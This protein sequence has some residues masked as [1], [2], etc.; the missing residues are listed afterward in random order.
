MQG[1]RERFAIGAAVLGAAL[2]IGACGGDDAETPTPPPGSL[3]PVLSTISG[4]SEGSPIGVGWMS[5]EAIAAPAPMARRL[6]EALGPNGSDVYDAGAALQRIAGFDPRRADQLVSVGG[7]YAFGLRLEGVEPARLESLLRR[8]GGSDRTEDGTVLVDVG[9]PFAVP[10]TL[11][12]AG[13]IGL[14]ARDAIGPTGLILAA[15]DTGR[16]ALLGGDPA[17]LANPY[18]AAASSCLGNVVAARLIPAKLL[19]STEL[20]ASL[21]AIGIRSVRPASAEVLCLVGVDPALAS[22][23]AEAVGAALAGDAH[24]PITR[25]PMSTW[26]AASHAGAFEAD[27]VSA[28]RVELEPATREG[29]VLDAFARGTLGAIS[30][31]TAQG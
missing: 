29:F 8:A 31:R 26:L 6:A 20:G 12:P 11:I 17:L 4:A 22:E 5:D 7:S 3:E 21:V 28:V 13:R 19:G 25:R 9:D 10:S 14:G 27:G 15:S 30:L 1:W 2:G 18:Y 24:D 16:D 23:R